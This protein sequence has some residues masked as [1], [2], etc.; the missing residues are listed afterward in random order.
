MS[1]LRRAACGLVVALL[2]GLLLVL[3]HQRAKPHRLEIWVDSPAVGSLW[4]QARCEG[5]G[6]EAYRHREAIHPGYQRLR[7]P[8]PAC[9]L[10][11]LTLRSNVDSARVAAALVSRY[12]VPRQQLLGEARTLEGEGFLRMDAR[13]D[14]AQAVALASPLTLPAGGLDTRAPGV[15]ALQLMFV[16]LLVWLAV[17][18]LPRRDLAAD[19]PAPFTRGWALALLLAVIT[20]AWLVRTDVSLS[21]DE[22]TH[23]TTAR[24]HFEHWVK[25]AIGAAEMEPAY[26]A[27]VY[28]ISYLN[29]TDPVY[30][31]AAKFA[32]AAWPLLQDDVLGLRLFNVLLLAWVL[33][34]AARLRR[35]FMFLLPLLLMPQAWYLFAYFNGDALPY[36]LS[37]MLYL[38]ALAHWTSDAP[39]SP[40]SPGRALAFGGLAGLLLL[41]KQNYW[42]CLVLL[43]MLWMSTCRP[44][45]DVPAWRRL[46]WAALGLVMFVPLVI[47]GT[48]PALPRALPALICLLVLATLL[49]WWGWRQWQARGHWLP[50]WRA[51]AWLALGLCLVI[52]VKMTDELA[53]NAA[54]WAPERA[55]AALAVQEKF[56]EASM[57]PS[58]LAAG[59]ANSRY[60]MRNQ[61]KGLVELQERGWLG[62]SLRTAFGSYGYLDIESPALLSS[63][64]QASLLGVL[65]LAFW[66][67][68]P[69]A[70][71]SGV[72]Q[73]VLVNCASVIVASA[74]FSWTGDYQPQGRYLLSIV[75]MLGLGLALV[76]REDRVPLRWVA[77]IGF[78]LSLASFVGVGTA[79]LVHVVH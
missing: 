25:P 11:A 35:G 20:M 60:R 29:A 6:A 3:V 37:A 42:P 45:L 40:W 36:A 58:A 27:N 66:R 38:L 49:A 1:S 70:E 23:V 46:G 44:G 2:V 51:A 5:S 67:Q 26:R 19:A 68:R 33:V 65:A 69:Q 15:G 55:A 71:L 7:L 32:V 43:A 13:P 53:H 34:A 31:L 12:G 62:Q 14:R 18:L 41:S 48:L 50:R 61:G 72:R 10:E 64:L 52:G 17:L 77:A 22:G 39:R 76:G 8:L 30:V 78:A 63:A 59:D 57:R 56:A 47:D 21:P 75:P 9:R 16:P 24:Y 73:A 74:L 4:L 54:P 79:G 28:G